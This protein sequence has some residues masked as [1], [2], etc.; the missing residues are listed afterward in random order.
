MA[1]PLTAKAIANL[2]PG[3]QRREIPDGGCHGLYFVLQPSGR[4]AWAVR[5]R[6]NGK[7]KKLTLDSVGSLA[8]ARKAATAALHELDRGNDP[9][10]LKFDA[11]AKAET[12]ATDRA[13]D[14]IERWSA[15][16]L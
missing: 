6:F 10:A 5:Y 8:E 2:K 4:R 9:A 3:A 1:K 11:R 15:E 16:Y 12:A 7:P 14:T 13:S